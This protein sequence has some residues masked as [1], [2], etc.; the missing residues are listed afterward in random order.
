M[1]CEVTE[2]ALL[3]RLNRK[4]KKEGRAI[5]KCSQNYRDYKLLGD[6]F[7]MDF[8]KNAHLGTHINLED[9]GRKE[10]VL[11]KYEQLK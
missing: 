9:F 2:K 1:I 3:A 6:Y 7:E 4:L 10:G 8:L 11:E 5:R